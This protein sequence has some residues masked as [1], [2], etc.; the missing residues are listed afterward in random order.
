MQSILIEE[1]EKMCTLKNFRIKNTRPQWLTNEITEQM[2][3]R[4]YFYKKKAK[5]TNS[6]DDWNI[7]KFYRNEVNA[8][9][10][11]AKAEFVKEQLR[12]NE[13][14]SAKFWRSIKQVMPS[15]KGPKSSPK[16]LLSNENDKMIPEQVVADYMNTFFANIGTPSIVP[17]GEVDNRPMVQSQKSDHQDINF[18]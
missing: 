15:K 2:K 11:G 12:N 5:R 4:D 9:V 7:A 17:D 8:N 1:A 18:T 6:T 10:R 16:I 13:G 3:D 14:N